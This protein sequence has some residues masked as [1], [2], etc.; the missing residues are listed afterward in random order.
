MSLTDIFKDRSQK[1]TFVNIFKNCQKL[2]K[3]SGKLIILEK[4][5]KF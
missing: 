5:G 4:L 3:N 2:F 1:F